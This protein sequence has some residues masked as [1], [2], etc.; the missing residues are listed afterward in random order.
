MVLDQRMQLRLSKEQRQKL[1]KDAADAGL[2]LTD[3][4][5]ENLGK[6]AVVNREDWKRLVYLVAGMANNLNQIAKSV[7]T[8]GSASDVVVINASLIGIERGI[9]GIKA[10]HLDPPA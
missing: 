5:R 6:T 9:H 10:L 8:L 2:S 4:V 3:F 7:N 1:E